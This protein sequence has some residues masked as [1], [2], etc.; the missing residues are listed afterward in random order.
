MAER[1]A[2]RDSLQRGL[3]IIRLL[4]EVESDPALRHKGLAVN[5]VAYELGVHKST[6]SRLLRTLAD[7]GFAVLPA[8]TRRGYRLGPALRSRFGLTEAQQR[9]RELASPYLQKLVELTGECAH[10]A[11]ASG[12]SALVID[13]YETAQSLRVVLEKGRHLPLHSTSVGKCLLAWELAPVPEVLP[14]R[15][16]RTITDPEAL[17]AHLAAVREQGYAVDDEEN[18]TGGYGISAPVFEGH[19]GDAVGCLGIGLPVQRALGA[20]AE[21]AAQVVSTADRLSAALGET[22]AG[23]TG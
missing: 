8:G 23:E 2:G 12:D 15:T 9:F 14:A 20:T 21:L 6:A 7:N 10:V 3:T 19:G 4:I 5:E 16:E 11:V 22:S 1:G 18:H 17:R 13:A